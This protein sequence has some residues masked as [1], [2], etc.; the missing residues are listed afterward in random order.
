[1]IPSGIVK[2][3]VIWRPRISIGPAAPQRVRSYR[4][5]NCTP[6][7]G[8]SF[9]EANDRSI[10]ANSNE[11]TPGIDQDRTFGVLSPKRTVYESLA[12]CVAVRVLLRHSSVP[13]GPRRP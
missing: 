2:C 1:V 9:Q 10:V 5:S 4:K 13:Q 3:Q 6:E 12:G 8:H 7:N 11:G